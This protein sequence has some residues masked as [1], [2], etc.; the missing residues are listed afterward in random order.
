MD[1]QNKFFIISFLP[2]LAYWYLEANYDLKIALIGGVGLAILEISF[3]KFFLKHV[4]KISL[5]NFYLIVFLGLIAFIG[6]DGI[7]Y[8]LQPF[9]TGLAMSGFLFYKKIK[10]TSFMQEMMTEFGNEP[11]LSDEAM[12][13][14]E[15]HMA[16]FLLV[17]G[18]FMAAVAITMT[19]DQWIFFKTIGFYIASAVF[20]LI[21]MVIIRKEIIKN[22]ND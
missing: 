10:N 19:T 21:E 7:W 11:V 3:E 20:F 9:F 13:K 5:F 8:K 22:K 17:Y 2:A 15:F 6:N 12:K 16:I 1:K 14:M 18:C 4:H